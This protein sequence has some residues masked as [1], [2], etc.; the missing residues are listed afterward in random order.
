MTGLSIAPDEIVRQVEALVRRGFRGATPDEAVS[1]VDPRLLHVTFD[2][3]YRSVERVLPALRRLEVPATIFVCTELAAAGGAPLAIAELAEERRRYPDELL[4]MDWPTLRRLAGAGVEIGSHTRT[5]AHLTRL[6]DEA[7]ERELVGSRQAIEAALGRPCRYVA[8]PFGEED[9][10]VRAAAAAAGYDAAFGMPGR[11]G[12]RMSVPR[13]GLYRRDSPLRVRL[14]TSRAA[15]LLLDVRAGR[16]AARRGSS[17]RRGR[18]AAPARASGPRPS[19]APRRPAG[20]RA[21]TA[22]PANA[23]RDAPR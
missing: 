12:D 7:L 18:A 13:V 6:D 10:R 14:K 3:A 22:C 5:H 2:D 16:A 15:A 21:G 23:A 17:D 4:T 8:Y 9:A 20:D 11:P 19:H 1:A